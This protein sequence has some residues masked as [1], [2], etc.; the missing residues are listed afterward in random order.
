MNAM[1]SSNRETALWVLLRLGWS[2]RSSQTSNGFCNRGRGFG[3]NGLGDKILQIVWTGA[4][5]AVTDELDVIAAYYQYIQNSFFG[6]AARGPAP[7][8]GAEHSQC[9]GTFYA[10]SAAVDWK[11]APKWDLYA[12][13]VPAAM[14]ADE[15]A[16]AV[17]F[18]QAGGLGEHESQRRDVRAQRIIRRDRLRHQVWPLRLRTHIAIEVLLARFRMR[19]GRLGRRDSNLCILESVFA[20]TFS[21]GARTRI[22][23]SRRVGVMSAF[24]P[25]RKWEPIES[26]SAAMHIRIG[27]IVP[28]VHTHERHASLHCAFNPAAAP[29][30]RA[31]MVFQ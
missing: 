12:V 3:V 10:I 18:A 4:K 25:P 26:P 2:C 15:D 17:V 1:Y 21:P 5:Y 6:T 13:S 9:A 7:C 8:S 11:F 28:L 30:L 23:A 20:Q 31:I 16:V 27:N 29:G 24:F 22:C 19:T 14:L